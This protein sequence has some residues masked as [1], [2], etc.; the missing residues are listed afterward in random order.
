MTNFAPLL[1]VW[2]Y[3]IDVAPVVDICPEQD[4]VPPPHPRSTSRSFALQSTFK[5]DFGKADC[6]PFYMSKKF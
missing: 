6:G 4:V 5:T 3:L 1:P 2:D